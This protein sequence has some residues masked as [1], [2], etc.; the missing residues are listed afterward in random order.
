MF[1]SLKVKTDKNTRA[2]LSLV[3]AGLWENC[4][5]FQV[6]GFKFQDSV[7]WEKVYLLAEEQSVVGLVLAGIERLKNANH[8]LEIDQDLLLQLIGEVQILEQQN[9]AM[10]VFVAELIEKLRKDK[11]HIVV[12]RR[13]KHRCR[14][15]HPRPSIASEEYIFLCFINAPIY[16][17][18]QTTMQHPVKFHYKASSH[19]HA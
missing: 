12:R 18:R 6:S 7:D 16:T 10:N 5:E 1:K 8:H 9:K 3:R 15:I 17:F 11:Y 2:F 14:A 13:Q 4:D 19:S